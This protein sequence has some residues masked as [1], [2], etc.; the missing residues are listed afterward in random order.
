MMASIEELKMQRATYGSGLVE[1]RVTP[2]TA[3]SIQDL[4]ELRKAATK[5]FD[6]AQVFEALIGPASCDKKQ[7]TEFSKEAAI[8]IVNRKL[9]TL[10]NTSESISSIGST[11]I[12]KDSMLER[13]LI[14]GIFSWT[15][16][17]LLYLEEELTN[18]RPADVSKIF[19]EKHIYSGQPH[20]NHHHRYGHFV[21]TFVL[22]RINTCDS[23]LM[24]R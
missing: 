10:L 14:L 7:L 22:A 24:I 9:N 16:L 1:R 4:P 3:V 21:N 5:P 2:V 12:S 17:L 18:G 19:H 20:E 11:F 6:P 15:S 8:F 23:R 13:G